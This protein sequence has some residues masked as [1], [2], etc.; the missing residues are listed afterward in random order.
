MSTHRRPPANEPDAT[1]PGATALARQVL[2]DHDATRD[3]LT[4]ETVA[5]LKEQVDAHKHRDPARALQIAQSA[6]AVA[7]L[8]GDDESTALAWWAAGTAHVFMF[9]LQE[10]HDA[11]RRAAAIYERKAQWVELVNVQAPLVYV[12]NAR[13]DADAALAL[14]QCCRDRC[15]DLGAAALSALVNLEMNVGTIHKQQGQFVESLRA[16]TRAANA[17][18]AL[19]DSASL[20]RIGIN[21]ANVYQEMDRFE[22]AARVYQ[23][24]RATLVQCA[25]NQQQVALVDLNLGLL[26]DNCGR[27]LDALRH[28]EAARDG[29][30]PEVH[31]AWVDFN[32]ARIYSRLHLNHETIVLVER[33]EKVLAQNDSPRELA[34]ALHV[35]AQAHARLG[36]TAEADGLLQRARQLFAEQNA[37]VML[38]RVD[39]SLAALRLQAGEYRAAQQLAQRLIER[40]DA[41]MWP[42]IAAGAFVL[43]AES[44]LAQPAPA[45]GAAV[46]DLEHALALVRQRG[47]PELTIRVHCLLGRAHAGMGAEPR[48][49]H[50]TVRAIAQ[51]EAL[52][53]GLLLDEFQLGFTHERLSVYTDAVEWLLRSSDETPAHW[54]LVLYV[55]TLPLLLAPSHVSAVGGEAS[56]TLRAELDALRAEWHWHQH[57]RQRLREGET[58]AAVPAVAEDATERAV[59]GEKCAELEAQIADV[60]RRLGVRRIKDA[61]HAF[62]TAS[63]DEK[64]VRL[65]AH[66]LCK[67]V[68][69]RLQPGHLLLQYFLAGE[70]IHVLRITRASIDHQCLGSA[71]PVDRAMRAWRY[72]LRDVA[73][74]S[75][76]PDVALSVAQ[77][78]L[79]SLHRT[80]I[81]PVLP[82]KVSDEASPDAAPHLYIVLPPNWH[83]IPFAALCHPNGYLV[84]QFQITHLSSVA[85]LLNDAPL[86]D[87]SPNAA[88]G[89]HAQARALV[90]GHSAGGALPHN[91][92][93]A[94]QLAH[95]LG[96]TH[97]TTLL[98]DENATAARFYHAA[99]QSTLIHLATHATF[100]AENPL[101]SW[102]Q[103]ADAHVTVADLYHG[104]RL[105]NQPLVVLSACETGRGDPLGSGLLGM[106]RALQAAG[107]GQMIA[108]QWRVED[109]ATARLMDEFYRR[110]SATR[111]ARPDAQT[112][113]AALRAAQ[114]TLA[115]DLHPFYWAGWVFIAG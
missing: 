104:A 28:L 45:W 44:I 107:A 43:R 53:A 24:S 48:A 27:Y 33:A 2:A 77:R 25:D 34:M 9:Q 102:L 111:S 65:A 89:V 40:V 82:A 71:A 106:A 96:D 61:P 12:L 4:R 56:Q 81:E 41:D 87:A 113:G 74:I 16:C 21:R 60:W 80:L 26:A 23:F 38:A 62:P 92:H 91:V 72:H 79:R 15:L 85:A 98:A 39:L 18:K 90:V 112:T 105:E 14:A 83:E 5:A 88:G 108:T 29:F 114:R 93:E 73:L 17:A 6:L 7:A 51:T 10:A 46:R 103:L 100:H 75:D 54:A 84:E 35:G 70:E 78:A 97:N 59:L 64:G 55:L 3:L 86:S 67:A 13:G 11:Y 66:E 1:A 115:R 99:Q 20:A 19:G 52:R 36:H 68:Q 57:K 42:T 63:L 31:A 76:A 50:H 94:T 109:A 101:F 69:Q 22:D 58:A 47:A 30:L 95:R 37:R 32:R 8:L 49:W 110:W